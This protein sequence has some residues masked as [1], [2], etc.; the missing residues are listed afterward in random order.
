MAAALH[1]VLLANIEVSY[2]AVATIYVLGNVAAILSHVP[3]GLGV[4]EAVVIYLLP[5]A[6][7]IGALLAFRGLYFF[8]PFMIGIAL[9]A[10][11]EV[12]QQRLGATRES[13]E[14]RRAAEER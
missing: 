7:V 14:S 3:G 10:T 2:I 11:Y 13:R 1:Q 12:R 6:A 4:L 9:F 8:L 5:Q